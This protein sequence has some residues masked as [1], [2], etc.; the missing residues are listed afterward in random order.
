MLVLFHMIL[1]IP[2]LSSTHSSHIHRMCPFWMTQRAPC[3]LF[4]NAPPL[5]LFQAAG[6]SMKLEPV[7]LF[8]FLFTIHTCICQF[9]YP[10]LQILMNLRCCHTSSTSVMS[11]HYSH[12]FFSAQFGAEIGLHSK[13]Q[14]VSFFPSCWLK[15]HK[16]KM[17]KIQY[18]H[19]N[20]LSFFCCK[21]KEK[22][23][24]VL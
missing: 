7:S 8:S 23:H 12:S 11:I 9:R 1:E 18:K 21:D 16:L 13:C 24:A 5:P 4:L 15:I 2:L 14:K 22:G 3:A 20:L 6:N 19:D 10:I 17:L